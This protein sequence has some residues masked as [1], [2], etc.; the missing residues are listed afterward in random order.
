VTPFVALLTAYQI[1]LAH[2]GD[3]TDVAVASVFA[4]RDRARFEPLIGLCAGLT[5]LRTSL[6]GDPTLGE[7]LDRVRGVV[8]DA[9]QHQHLPYRRYARELG[10]GTSA[11]ARLP[12]W[13]VWANATASR[14]GPYGVV[15][16]FD[17]DGLSVSAHTPVVD[18]PYRKHEPVWE[19]DNLTLTVTGQG[20]SIALVLDYNSLLLPATT[21]ERVTEDCVRVLGL[22]A[23]TPGLALSAARGRL[24]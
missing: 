20:S 3:R 24:S 19:G 5:V 10:L 2:A 14:R 6:A 23:G 9:H 15:H 18:R 22:L 13:D 21:V 1:S 12:I 16:D 4:G 11:D 8:L 17:L 7:A